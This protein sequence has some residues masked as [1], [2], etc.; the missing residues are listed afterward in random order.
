MDLSLILG[1]RPIR[2]NIAVNPT[3][4][5]RLKSRGALIVKPREKPDLTRHFDTGEVDVDSK[6]FV[7]YSRFKKALLGRR[8]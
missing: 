8:V 3:P 2:T 5:S 6:D 7:D 1:E 4:H